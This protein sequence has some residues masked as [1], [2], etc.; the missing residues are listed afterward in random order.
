[1]GIVLALAGLGVLS[2]CGSGGSKLDAASSVSELES[3]APRVVPDPSEAA[4]A[5]A[6]EEDFGVDVLQALPGDSNLVFSPHSMS[7]AFAMLTGAAAGD[8]LAQ[9]A[10]TLRFGTT[11]DAFQRSEDAL[12]TELPKRNRDAIHDGGR[13]VE[14]QIL[15]QSND[16][17]VRR[18]APPSAGYL[19]F[20][21]QY[22]G[23][24]VHV[25]DF[26][27]APE[28]VRTA[29]NDKVSDD[30]HGLI[31][32]LIPKGDIDEETLLV[33]TNA[34]YFKAPW[35][36]AFGAPFAGS[37][38]LR[39]GSTSTVDTL[40]A[41]VSAPYLAG[42][43]FVSVAVP[44]FGGELELMLIVPDLGTYD[45]FRS[46]FTSAML[47]DIVAQRSTTELTLSLPKFSVQS[48]VPAAE[49]LKNLG[50]QVPFTDA[51]D[52]PPLTSPAF[53]EVHISDV[54]HQATIAVDQNG[55][56]ASA[57][58]AVVVVDTAVAPG[59]PATTV[60]VDRPF[61]F[62]LRDNPTGALLFFG[63]VVAP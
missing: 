3:D 23:T 58:T 34:L 6:S 47:D 55:T 45:A 7:T 38:R 28:Q 62:A 11:D 9:I 14:A 27:G 29:I 16:V 43:G 52:F 21:A 25:A 1:M 15:N 18:D 51:A 17:W 4:Q 13:N 5:S 12:G 57:A 61:L 2:G 54:L 20:L 8:T 26:A 50:M 24:G 35:A 32:E 41:V 37:F 33:L 49:M 22:Y 30:T 31:T 39:D 48:V 19:D 53:P 59:L 40:S 44:Y 36:E 42:D 10:D 56:E 46:T 63:Q 60:N